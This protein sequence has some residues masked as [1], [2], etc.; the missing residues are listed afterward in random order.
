VTTPFVINAPSAGTYHFTMSYGECCSGPA[1]LQWFYQ[2]GG[3]VGSVPE[4]SSWAMMLLGFG[5]IGMVVRRRRK[6]ALFRL[7]YPKI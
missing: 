1:V 3:A 2:T 7:A 5:G 4:P 6:D